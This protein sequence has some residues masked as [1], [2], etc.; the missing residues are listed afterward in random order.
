MYKFQHLVHLKNIHLLAII[1]SSCYVDGAYLWM[2]QIIW[3]GD[4][5]VVEPDGT[6][7]V[8]IFVL[9]II[10]SLIWFVSLQFKILI[11]LVDLH[12]NLFSYSAATYTRG[13]IFL[14]FNFWTSSN[15]TLFKHKAFTLILFCKISFLQI[16]LLIIH[17][18]ISSM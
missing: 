1:W 3:D 7:R 16:Q 8:V 9:I 17:I 5:H 4:G 10:T 11:L 14:L 13:Q 18:L 15:L 2:L 12:P 6:V